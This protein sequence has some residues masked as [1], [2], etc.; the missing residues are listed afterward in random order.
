[1]RCY[2][3]WKIGEN[4]V[5][6]IAIGGPLDVFS[7]YGGDGNEERLFGIW[8]ATL[9]VGDEFVEVQIER[10]AGEQFVAIGDEHDE[11][12]FGIG[13]ER[14]EVVGNQ[15][16][17]AAAVEF[18]AVNELCGGAGDA[19]GFGGFPDLRWKTRDAVLFVI[20]PDIDAVAGLNLFVETGGNRVPNHLNHRGFARS[21][22]EGGIDDEQEI[23][24]GV[25]RFFFRLGLFL[26]GKDAVERQAE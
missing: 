21:H 2:P 24:L 20:G 12:P 4:A 19:F 25:R 3:G 9:L 15:F 18:Q 26:L 13:E 23:M 17:M 1:M 22:G 7:I 10:Y 11:E 16:K 14:F 5:A 6:F 8:A